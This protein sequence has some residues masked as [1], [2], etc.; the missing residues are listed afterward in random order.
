MSNSGRQ[1]DVQVAMDRAREI[2][3][4]LGLKSEVYVT[5]SRLGSLQHGSTSDLDLV[6]STDQVRGRNTRELQEALQEA[7]EGTGVD[8][9]FE[10]HEEIQR[11]IRSGTIRRI[12]LFGGRSRQEGKE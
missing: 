11:G 3:K 10:P 6:L 7:L 12:Q 1:V 8:I 9:G 4:Q 2:I 5:G